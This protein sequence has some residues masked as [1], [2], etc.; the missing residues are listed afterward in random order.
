MLYYDTSAKDAINVDVAFKAVAE[1]A[2]QQLL[3]EQEEMYARAT[4]LHIT[5]IF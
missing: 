5:C 4:Y 3:L 1:V 2:L